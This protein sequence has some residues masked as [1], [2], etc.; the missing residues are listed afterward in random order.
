MPATIADADAYLAQTDRWEA[1]G[2]LGDEDKQRALGMA[3]L[4]LQ[5]AYPCLESFE[6]RHAFLQASYMQTPD[7][8]ASQGNVSSMSASMTGVSVSWA[9][10]KGVLRSDGLDPLLL[11]L[12]GDPDV[13]CPRRGKVKRGRVL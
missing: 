11:G 10:T 6:D 12:I 3:C 7:Y 1:W 13:V 9:R 2:E 5:S 4:K 8:A